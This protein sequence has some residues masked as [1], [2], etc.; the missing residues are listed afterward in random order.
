MTDPKFTHHT[1]VKDILDGQHPIRQTVMSLENS[2]QIFPFLDVLY[3]VRTITYSEAKQ[4]FGSIPGTI[5]ARVRQCTAGEKAYRG[6]AS[7]L[8]KLW[9][10]DPSANPSG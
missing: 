2:T 10:P 8:E 4:R 6:Y 9:L 7:P 5:G 3:L 1:D